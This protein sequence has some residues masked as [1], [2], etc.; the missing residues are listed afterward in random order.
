MVPQHWGPW[1][2]FLH[3]ELGP[4]WRGWIPPSTDSH[5]SPNTQESLNSG[6]VQVSDLWSHS[7]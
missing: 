6:Y 2:Q 7:G 5:P 1:H 4:G 3:P